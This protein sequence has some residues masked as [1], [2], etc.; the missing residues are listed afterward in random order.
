MTGDTRKEV[1]TVLTTYQFSE[2]QRRQQELQ[3]EAEDRRL[4]ARIRRSQS[5]EMAVRRS[6]LHLRALLAR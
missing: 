4:A 2:V 1:Q 3:R 5:A 6:T